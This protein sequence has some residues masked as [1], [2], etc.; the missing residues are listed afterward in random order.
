WRATQVAE[1]TGGY[2]VHPHLDPQWTDGY[3]AIA[4]EIRQA[5]PEGGSLVFPLGGGGLLMGLTEFFRRPPAPSKLFGVEPRNYP[6]YAPFTHERSRTIADGLLLDVP[7]PKVQQRIAEDGVAVELV[8]EEDI[9]KAMRG[10]YEA[11]G[12]VVEPS[13]AITVAFVRDHL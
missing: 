3:Q 7:H 8:N 5:L 11:H 9:G 6:T 2:F 1:E 10:L 4:A 12:L 13:S